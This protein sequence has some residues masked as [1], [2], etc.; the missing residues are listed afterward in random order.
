MKGNK[1]NIIVHISICKNTNMT[2]LQDM[3]KEPIYAP[4]FWQLQMQTDTS[5][6][7]M[8]QLPQVALPLGIWFSEIMN[9]S[10]KNLK[11]NICSPFW[12]YTVFALLENSMH[13]KFIRQIFCVYT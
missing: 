1:C 2:S 5:K 11:P 4:Y 10:W 8:T 13:I 7:I 12:I 6:L 3:V 9:N